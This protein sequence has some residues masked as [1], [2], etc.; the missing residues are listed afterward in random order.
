M[1]NQ[2]KINKEI[3]EHLKI[4]GRAAYSKIADKIG[5]SESTVRKRVKKMI[6]DNIIDRFTMI[7][8]RKGKEGS[9]LSFLTILSIKPK[10]R[11]GD[12]S[13]RIIDFPEV[14]EAY[15]LS[16]RCGVLVKVRVDSLLDLDK[17]IDRIRDL[18]GVSKIENCI[19][20]KEF[21]KKSLAEFDSY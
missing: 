14:E 21:K 5:V 20:L 17:L 9:V 7:L 11:L 2:D 13:K 12:L 3:I 18:H 1:S 8:K 19:V 6:E 10:L 16:G 4:D 15:Y